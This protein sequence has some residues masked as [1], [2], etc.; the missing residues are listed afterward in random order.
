MRGTY[1]IKVLCGFI[2]ESLVLSNLPLLKFQ[3]TMYVMISVLDVSGSMGIG[4]SDDGHFK[5]KLQVAKECLTSLV[6]Q[7]KP[8]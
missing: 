5:S 3:Y 2:L 6:D 8:E 7:L 4:F 1:F